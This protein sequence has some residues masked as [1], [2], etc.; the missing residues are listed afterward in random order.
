MTRVN[1]VVV[2]HVLGFQV[3]E[4]KKKGIEAVTRVLV[5]RRFVVREAAEKLA[6]MFC[7]AGHDAWVREVVG[8][9]SKDKKPRR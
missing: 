9:E 5:T 3:V 2:P 6:A 7:K 8:I 4:T 1:E